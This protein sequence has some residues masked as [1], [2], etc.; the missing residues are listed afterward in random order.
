[1]TRLEKFLTALTSFGLFCLMASALILLALLASG[2]SAKAATDTTPADP[3]T[4]VL[5][6]A[7]IPGWYEFCVESPILMTWPQ[8]EVIIRRDLGISCGMTVNDIRS[9]FAQQRRAD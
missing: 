5:L 6:P 9:Y 4:R 1:M 3:T 8:E 7:N 2:C